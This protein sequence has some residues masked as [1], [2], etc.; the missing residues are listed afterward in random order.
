MSASAIVKH[1]ASLRDA[2]INV[3]LNQFH[4]ILPGSGVAATRNHAL[5]LFQET[6]AITGAIKRNALQALA[7]DLNTASLIPDTPEGE[8]ERNRLRRSAGVSPAPNRTG[9][10]RSD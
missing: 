2:W 1:H 8:D 3:L 9:S 4:D 7:R 6:G 10:A 5:G